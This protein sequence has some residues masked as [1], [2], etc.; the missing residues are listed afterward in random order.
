[1]ENLK[2][3]QKGLQKLGESGLKVNTE[4]LFFKCTETQNLS[5]WVSKYEVRILLS[6]VEAI[7]AIAEP[8]K[9]GGIHCFVG[10]VTYNRDIWRNRAHKLGPKLSYAPLRPILNGLVQRKIIYSNK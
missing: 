8:T 5:F 9:A 7:K 4:N 6:K 10:I 3:I 2:D 1:M